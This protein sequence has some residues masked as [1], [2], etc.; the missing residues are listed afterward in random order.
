MKIS[1]GTV[2]FGGAYGAFNTRGQ[3]PLDEVKEILSMA[4]NAGVKVLDTAR[5]YG[6]AEKVLAA[7]NAPSDF[8]II[9][10]CPALEAESDPVGML[11]AAFN[12]STKTL[13]VKQVHG[14]L[15]HNAEDIVIPGV[16]EALEELR[17]SGR[18]K[19]IGVS[20]YDAQKVRDYCDDY[21]LNFVQLPANILDPWYES[22]N[23][24]E[25]VEVHVRSVFLQGFLVGDPTSLP[26]HLTQFSDVLAQFQAEASIQGLSPLQAALSPLLACQQVDKIVVGAD[27]PSQISEILL[28]VSI[29]SGRTSPAF[30][31]FKG[32]TSNLTDPRKW[33]IS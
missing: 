12:A 29:L 33:G 28:A 16:F 32:V 11:Q 8:D 19:G 17:D 5:A 20:G 7:V 13:G 23:F 10:K 15:L 2:Q 18:T 22:I 21:S 30:G 14:Y 3:V 9:T 24:P 27:N 1:L 31:P 4:K 26:S 6:E 25:D